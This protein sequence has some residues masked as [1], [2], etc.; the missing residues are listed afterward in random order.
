MVNVPLPCHLPQDHLLFLFYHVAV[1]WF[2]FFFFSCSY[3]AACGI[4]VSWPRIKPGPFALEARSL[5]YW[6]TSEVPRGTN[7]ISSV[8]QNREEIL[9]LHLAWSHTFLSS[10]T[11]S[12]ECGLFANTEKLCIK[13]GIGSGH[14]RLSQQEL[15]SSQC[16]FLF[17]VSELIFLLEDPDDFLFL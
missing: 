17:S 5:N 1:G 10:V 4:L 7:F 14:S 15:V 9:E 12:F 16:D 11:F 2:F 8:F 3:S 6:A 13:I